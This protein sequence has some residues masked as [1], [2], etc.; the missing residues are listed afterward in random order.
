MASSHSPSKRKRLNH[1]SVLPTTWIGGFQL[2]QLAQEAIEHQFGVDGWSPR[3]LGSLGSSDAWSGSRSLNTRSQYQH[4]Y[5]LDLAWQHPADDSLPLMLLQSPNVQ[6]WLYTQPTDM[7][8]QFDGL[9]ALAKNKMAGRLDQD[10]LFVFMNRKRTYLKALHY[11]HGGL[12]LWSKR[13]EQGHYQS[14]LCGSGNAVKLSLSWTELQCLIDG[15][16]W[17][18]MPKNKRYYR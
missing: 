11:S 12:C 3:S 5:Y 4:G 8:K 18:K 10:Q 6:I 14:V 1:F 15:I 7:R 16:Q 17:Q 2:L 13:L 9:A